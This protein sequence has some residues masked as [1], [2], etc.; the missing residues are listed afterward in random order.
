MASGNAL[1]R[2][3]ERIADVIAGVAD[4]FLISYIIQSR[5]EECGPHSVAFTFAHCLELSIKAAYWQIKTASP[6]A[7]HQVAQLIELLRPGLGDQLLSHL[8]SEETR[9]KFKSHVDAMNAAPVGDMLKWFFEVNPNFDDGT[10]M[11]LY[12]LFRPVHVKYGVDKQPA[13]LQM[14]LGERLRLNETGLRLIGCSREEF[15]NQQF[16][17]ATLSRF[18]DR[19]PRRRTIIDALDEYFRTGEGE[20]DPT[21]E[22]K[23][24]GPFPRLTFDGGELDLLRDALRLR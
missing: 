6:P 12:A 1:P 18:I 10:W 21:V 15:P 19:L 3:A 17:K 4:Q 11:I 2:E 8:P 22:E 24:A 16:H 9:Q 20:F 7:N 5:F 23:R 14:M 13:I